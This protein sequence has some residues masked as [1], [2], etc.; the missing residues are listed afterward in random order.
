M[1]LWI[2]RVYAGKFC[3]GYDQIGFL[4]E[5]NFEIEKE[6][7]RLWLFK[8]FLRNLYLFFENLT[9]FLSYHKFFSENLKIFIFSSYQ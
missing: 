2:K 3:L 4:L 5:T 6:L 9:D 7:K 8:Y 1:I